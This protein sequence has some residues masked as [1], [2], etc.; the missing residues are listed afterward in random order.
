MLAMKL[1]WH[2]GPLEI[3]VMF[4]PALWLAPACRSCMPAK[5]FVAAVLS[6]AA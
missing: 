1:D 2:G 4:R 3:C 6:P 5:V